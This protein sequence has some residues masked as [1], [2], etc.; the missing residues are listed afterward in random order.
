[1]SSPQPP[2]ANEANGKETEVKIAV[3]SAEAARE[4]LL[5][6]GFAALHERAF[7][8]NEVYDTAAGE[9]L[10]SSRLLRLRDFRGHAILT[11][12]GPPEPGPHKSRPEFETH[13]Q[14]AAA[15]RQ[16]L[17]G[18]GYRLTFRYEKYRTTLQRTAEPGHAVLDE[19]PIGAFLEL[20]GPPAW[21][22]STAAALGFT[23]ANYI[24]LSYGS[25]YR[26]HCQRAG[27]PPTHLVFAR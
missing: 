13:V 2:S 8:S 6:A 25:L 17:H 14:S 27:I 11:F 1:M 7:E 23:P 21:I 24:L 3:P 5:R 4:R 22:D 18:L 16:I 9:L 10:L 19:T 26:E 12:K 15:L 20:E